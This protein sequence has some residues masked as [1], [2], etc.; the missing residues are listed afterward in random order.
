MGTKKQFLK[1]EIAFWA[2]VLATEVHKTD[3]F[4]HVLDKLDASLRA[5]NAHL[6]HLA[7]QTTEVIHHHA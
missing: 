7:E 6:N 3:N 1:D 5:Y 2:Q 4:T